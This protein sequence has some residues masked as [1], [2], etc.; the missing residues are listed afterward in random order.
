MSN[1]DDILET[2]RMLLNEK[3][4]FSKVI[5]DEMMIFIEEHFKE[6]SDRN[7]GRY[8]KNI[9]IYNLDIEKELKDKIWNDYVMSAVWDFVIIPA[10]EDWKQENRTDI[11]QMGRCGGWLYLDS[12]KIHDFT[13]YESVKQEDESEDEYEDRMHPLRG[14]FEDLWN[15]EQWYQQVFEEV[16]EYLKEVEIKEDDEEDGD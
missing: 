6:H 15:F 1:N 14:L 10:I 8:C 3:E 13:N 2:K 5:P 11:Y 9:K 12:A 7:C 16:K 4:F